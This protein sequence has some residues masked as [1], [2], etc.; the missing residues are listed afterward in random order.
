MSV[1]SRFLALIAAAALT[2]TTFVLPAYAGPAPAAQT[3]AL[4]AGR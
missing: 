4:V 2:A 3:V 1:S